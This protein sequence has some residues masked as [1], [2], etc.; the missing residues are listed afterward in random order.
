MATIPAT[1]AAPPVPVSTTVLP[2]ALP[3][4]PPVA[5]G[6]GTSGGSL[7]TRIAGWMEEH[8]GRAA[9]PVAALA[10]GVVGGGLGFLALGPVGAA[11][12]GAAGAFG[13]A[14]LFMAG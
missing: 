4:D 5:S 14:L 1:A 10:G 13:G 3:A 7:R 11:V 6:S 12:G 9:M 8:L 2:P